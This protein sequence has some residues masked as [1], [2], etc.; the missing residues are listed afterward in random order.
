MSDPDPSTPARQAAAAKI[1]ANAT[2]YKVCEGCDSIV[3]NATSLC[4]ACHAYR[5][6]TSPNRVITQARLLGS[7]PQQTVLPDDLK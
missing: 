7:R 4:P 3:S 6:D 5:F 1:I 2:S